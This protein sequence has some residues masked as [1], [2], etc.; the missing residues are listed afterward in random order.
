MR[1]KS[2]R[3]VTYLIE[4]LGEF[5]F[6]FETILDYESGDQMGSY[7]VKNRHRKSHAWA[8]LSQTFS[9]L[10]RFSEND[11][12]L[13]PRFSEKILKRICSSPRIFFNN[14]SMSPRSLQ[15]PLKDL[16]DPWT[17]CGSFSQILRISEKVWHEMHQ[18]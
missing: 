4:Y 13:S 12:Q 11:W 3:T 5:E 15:Y 18:N 2:M 7:D 17:Q 1:T 8:P 16:G 14:I 6:I 10:L 9:E